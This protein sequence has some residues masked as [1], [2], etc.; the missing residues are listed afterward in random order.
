M[1]VLALALAAGIG[2][3]TLLRLQQRLERGAQAL[4]NR[5]SQPG[6]STRL[7][8]G[9]I[10]TT[11]LFCVGP[12]TIIGSIQ[13]GLTGDFHLIAVKA[14]MDGVAAC[15]FAATLGWGVLLSAGSV[16]II[17][18][19]ITL[20]AEM[21]RGFFTPPLVAELTAAGGALVLCIAVDLLGW[22]RL[23]V[24]DYLPAIILAPLLAHWGPVSENSCAAPCLRYTPLL[25]K[26]AYLILA[27][28]VG[29]S[30]ASAAVEPQTG[31][32]AVT[33]ENDS[34]SNPF[35]SHQDRHYTQ[36]L[37]VVLFGGDDFLTNVTA[38]LNRA[39][40]AWGIQPQA[41][42]LGLI[43]MGQNIYTPQNLTNA[44]PIKS[45]HPYAGW[46][47]TGLVFQRRGEL[48]ANLAVME[49]FE[50]NLGIVGP[51]S[52]AEEAQK[53]IH[54]WWF[55]DD[56]PRGWKYQVQTEPGLELKYARLW[57]YSPTEQSARYVDLI[58]RVGAELGNVQISATA[59][60]ALR[61]GYNLP[62]D[63]GV[64][65]IDSP[66]SVNGG[67]TRHTPWFSCY[68]FGGVDG[69]AVA[70]DITLDGNSFRSG[71]SVRKNNFVADL[72]WGVAFQIFRH[73]E[74]AYTRT[75]RT[76]QFRGQAGNDIFGSLTLKGTFW[77]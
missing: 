5:F 71:P 2:I 73:V 37:K 22:K 4:L 9:F 29:W 38:T 19:G 39:L 67:L 69:R 57:R 25:V 43:I 7:A 44:A 58:P 65:I 48:A 63:F 35:G 12:M 33:E 17:Q 32:L 52:I 76:E 13:D 45:D 64:P 75:F 34:L 62:A 10:T 6:Q 24:A 28:L 23:P 21:V 50:I 72:S 61:L 42:D 14:L 15:A 16:L 18:G 11:L 1:W 41:A 20:S 47:Y 70:H 8:E 59:G 74:I 54:R 30:A 46:L 77:F 55:P 49:N 60:A 36:G 51:Q 3:G 68:A 56:I 53:T 31:W 66:A 26:Y 40:P 27:G